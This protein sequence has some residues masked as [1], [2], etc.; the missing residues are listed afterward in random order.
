MSKVIDIC[1]RIKDKP[2]SSSETVGS[3]AHLSASQPK[4]SETGVLDM[5]ARRMAQLEEER[6]LV[7][8]TILN[9]FVGAC[10]LIP[11]RGLE[12]VHLHDISEDGIAFDLDSRKGSFQQGEQVAIRVYLNR[13]SFFPFVVDISNLREIPHEGIIRHGASFVLG[14]VNDI[15]LHHFVKFIESVSTSVR[16][17]TGDLLISSPAD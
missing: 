10:V 5:T 1:D 7:R 8:R 17:D 12:K 2:R 6:R 4:K 11:G 13:D 3:G 9:G 14:T 16:E 15:A